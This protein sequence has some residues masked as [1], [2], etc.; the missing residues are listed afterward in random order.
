MS[1]PLFEFLSPTCDYVCDV[2]WSPV[3]PA[4]FVTITSTGKVT[5]WN[6]SKSTTEPIDTISLFNSDDYGHN[7]SSKVGVKVSNPIALNK[8]LWSKDGQQILIGDSAGVIHKIKV[9]SMYAVPSQG[10]ENKFELVLLSPGRILNQKGGMTV[11]F[12]GV[13]QYNLPIEDEEF[14]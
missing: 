4:L 5:L 13:D 3:H 14:S 8:A 6:L 11:E 9:Q 1:E 12:N 7:H 10:E 2:Q